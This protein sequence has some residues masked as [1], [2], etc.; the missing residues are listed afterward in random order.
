MIMFY[1]PAQNCDIVKCVKENMA[2]KKLCAS[3]GLDTNVCTTC[4]K[5]LNMRCQECDPQK[6]AITYTGM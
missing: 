5:D 1:S 3:N 4:L 6:K 2:C